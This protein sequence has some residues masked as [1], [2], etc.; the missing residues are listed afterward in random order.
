MRLGVALQGHSHLIPTLVGMACEAIGRRPLWGMAEHLSADEARAAVRT[1]EGVNDAR[2]AS[3]AGTFTQEKWATERAVVAEFRAHSLPQFGVSLAEAGRE[4]SGRPLPAG[5][6]F[7]AGA[8]SLTQPKGAVLAEYG[9]YMDDWAAYAALPHRPGGTAAP[10]ELRGVLARQLTPA[11]SM[12]LHKWRDSQAQTALLTVWLALRAYAA[13][14]NG[15]APATLD[16]LVAAGYLVHVPTDPFAPAAGTPLRYR[17]A[18]TG[19][20]ILYSVGPD[21]VD[22][23]GTPL[24]NRS[25]DGTYRPWSNSDSKGDIVAGVNL[26]SGPT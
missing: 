18:D 15:A 16:E 3:A 25:T 7:A 21:S 8:V 22:N 2:P 23:G 19:R 5:E 13:D 20:S 6:R 14:H 1:L 9:R 11:L 24:D 12:S 17:R 10:R 26:H 4:E